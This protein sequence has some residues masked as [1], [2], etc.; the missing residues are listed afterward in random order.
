M[1]LFFPVLFFAEL[2]VGPMHNT[3]GIKP[4]INDNLVPVSLMINI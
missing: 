4:V 1:K 3:P 2:A